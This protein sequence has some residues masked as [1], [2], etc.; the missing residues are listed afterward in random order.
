MNKQQIARRFKR[1]L[2]SSDENATVQQEIAQTLASMIIETGGEQKQIRMLE[3]GCG[4]GM[5]TRRYFPHL[6]ISHLYLNDIVES[7]VETLGNKIT[8][9]A[10][11]NDPIIVSEH[12]G[13]AEAIPFP[14]SMDMIVAG[15]AVQWIEN[16]EA[17][18]EKIA[19]S[20]SPECYFIFNTFGPDNFMEI[21]NL[22]GVGLHYPETSLLAEMLGR[23]FHIEQ[24]T[25]VERKQWFD[26]PVA[27]LKHIRN[28]GVGMECKI[29][30]NKR[31]FHSFT[32]N[33]LDRYQSE[34]EVS[35][36]WDILYF[37]CRKRMR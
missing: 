23:Y 6:S 10:N 14:E 29:R 30:W 17:L 7:A 25:R 15:S 1:A 13:D 20:L 36:T 18:F 16:K 2:E 19:N 26:S 11:S 9:Q 3:I 32:N 24:H 28:T 21:K 27:V 34:G 22:T 8:S 31:T 4:T 12:P 33:Y 35:L 5:L 37:A